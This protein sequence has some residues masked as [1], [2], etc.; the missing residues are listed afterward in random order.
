MSA[1]RFGATPNK[2]NR[3]GHNL[4]ISLQLFAVSSCRGIGTS[5]A[6]STNKRQEGREF[7]MKIE[8]SF[9]AALLLIGT[10]FLVRAGV[11]G[12][13]QALLSATVEYGTRVIRAGRDLLP[14][15]IRWG[16]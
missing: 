7:L 9:L 8:V 11:Q 15:A 3:S 16:W 1:A 5:L 6:L 12:I 10:D 13:E 2:R 4:L 14:A